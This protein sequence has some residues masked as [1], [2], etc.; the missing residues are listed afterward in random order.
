ME[1]LH[2]RPAAAA[3][4]VAGRLCLDFVNLV[5][6]WEVDA[7]ARA[8]PVFAVRDD[9]LRDYADLIAFSL[10][11][12]IV[13]EARARALMRRAE[14]SPQ[15]ARGVWKRAVALR[16]ALRG[17]AWAFEQGRVPA[18]RDVAV[19]SEE[20]AASHRHRTLGA[21]PGRLEWRR[22]EEGASIEGPLGAI[23]GSA[24]DYFM[25]GDLTRLHT[26]PGDDC[27]WVFEDATRNRS[28]RWCDMG[29]CGNAAKVR[30]FRARAARGRTKGRSRR[31]AG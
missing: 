16:D 2:D 28:R 18:E 10:D 23:V 15:S 31:S 5:G 25:N 29:D 19:L 3:K 7:R 13:D 4:K 22:D 11:R 21:G 1:S 30:D 8:R 24:E 12:G 20:I 17:I 14:E 26:C 9:R 27:G 6:G